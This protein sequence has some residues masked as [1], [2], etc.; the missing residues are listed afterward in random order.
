MTLF[1]VVGR[2]APLVAGLATCVFAAPASATKLI[3]RGPG[4]LPP[5]APV[6]ARSTN[7]VAG[8][9]SCALAELHGEVVTNKKPTDQLRFTSGI[10]SG[11]SAVP[12]G[13]VT[14]ILLGF[15][16]KVK[17]THLGTFSFKGTPRLEWEDKFTPAPSVCHYRAANATNPGTF[18]VSTSP[19][20]V[21]LLIT[22]PW[23]INPVASPGCG[24]GTLEAT[25]EL[26]SLE[27][28]VTGEI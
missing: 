15:P 6:I 20:P 22:P 10:T 8:A 9:E 14:T 5:G 23:P 1:R 27:G 25:F 4:V 2:A 7:A 17:L 24:A 19:A 16:W 21:N 18:A 12:V 3:L 26:L 28:P 11:C 13:S